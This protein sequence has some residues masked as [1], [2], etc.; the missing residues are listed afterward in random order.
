MTY[1]PASNIAGQE[2]GQFLRSIE[3]I[4]RDRAALSAVLNAVNAEKRDLR[5][6]FPAGFTGTAVSK[7]RVLNQK[8]QEVELLL[9]KLKRGDSTPGDERAWVY[10]LAASTEHGAEYWYEASMRP[11][12]EYLAALMQSTENPDEIPVIVHP[13]SGVNID[14]IPAEW[15]DDTCPKTQSPKRPSGSLGITPAS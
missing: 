8:V 1:S 5:A 13:T 6:A 7:N 11:P 15:W 10:S 2:L 4:A 9:G 12:P 14:A 3:K